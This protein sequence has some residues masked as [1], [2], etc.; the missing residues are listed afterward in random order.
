[1]ACKH[2]YGGG[3]PVAEHDLEHAEGSHV[4]AAAE[5]DA[6]VGEAAIRLHMLGREQVDNA[7]RNAA[8]GHPG[9]RPGAIF[10]EAGLLTEEQLDY[11][12]QVSRFKAERI[13]D[14]RFGELAV[15]R[16]WVADG[17]VTAALETQKRRFIKGRQELRIGDLLVHEGLITAEQRDA[18]LAEQHRAKELLQRTTSPEAAGDEPAEPT[19]AQPETPASETEGG[20]AEVEEP[21]TTTRLLQVTIADDRLTAFVTL[22]REDQRPDREKVAAEVKNAGIA[23]GIDEAA[24]DRLVAE[25]APVGEPVAVARGVPTTPARDGEIE[26]LFETQPLRPGTQTEDGHIDF[27]DRGEIPQVAEG[28]LLARKTPAVDGEPGM[29]VF[30][31]TI[32]APKPR[33]PPLQA[34]SGA[35]LGEDKLGVVAGQAGNPRASATGVISVYPEYRIEEDLDYSTGHVDFQGRVVVAGTVRKG[36]RVRCGELVAQEIEE[37]DVEVEGDVRVEGGVLGARIRAGGSVKARYLHDTTADVTGDVIV[38]SEVLDSQLQ[39]SGALHAEGCTIFTSRISAKGGIH[40]KEIGSESSK[41]CQVTVGIDDPTLAEVERLEAEAAEKEQALES[42]P[43]RIEQLRARRAELDE[44]IQEHAQVQDRGQVRERELNAALEGGEGSPAQVRNELTQLQQEVK[45]AE[46]KLGAL[47][48]EQDRVMDEA[49]TL[50]RRLEDDRAAVEQLRRDARIRREWT[51]DNPGNPVVEVREALRSGTLIRTPHLEV[52]VS[53]DYP[54]IVLE[55][56]RS[57]DEHGRT[58]WRL[59]R[60]K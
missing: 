37:A 60:K 9:R 4:P 8:A 32:P 22:E 17:Q 46:E 51:E 54:R 53:R 16:G 59:A 2:L 1:M 42:L 13:A 56:R 57:V 27:R 18:L 35:A 29:D 58:T 12:E 28:E 15:E 55:E 25:D 14:K 43:E 26:Y 24:I 40:A 38:A 34:G 48:A 50:E 7:L 30:G 45:E 11:L 23:Y 49:D 44:E 21:Q 3:F 52:K 19:A 41:P 5:Q 6:Q 31:N 47:F 36:F 33:D 39:I 20:P 10:V